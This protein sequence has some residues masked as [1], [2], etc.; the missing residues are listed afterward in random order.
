M[1]GLF[2]AI[3]SRYKNKW[4]TVVFLTS[5]NDAQEP[6]LFRRFMFINSFVN[7]SEANG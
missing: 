6:Q 3:V 2:A 5:R 1:E 7:Q 4:K